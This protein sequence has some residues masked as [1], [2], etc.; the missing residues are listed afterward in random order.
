M[1]SYITKAI[2]G[3]DMQELK[4]RLS[5]VKVK[6]ID[7]DAISER[8]KN[9]IISAFIMTWLMATVYFQEIIEFIK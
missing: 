8:N 9:M 6:R 4:N 1:T 3:N 2:V 7:L 5:Q